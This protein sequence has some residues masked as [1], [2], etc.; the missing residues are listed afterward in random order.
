MLLAVVGAAGI[1][2]GSKIQQ[3]IT[4]SDLQ[5]LRFFQPDKLSVITN[6][7]AKDYVDTIN[8]NELIEKII[9]VVLDQLDPH[10]TYITAQEMSGVSEEMR[11]NFSGIG[12]QFI[13]QNDS[14]TVVDVV[15][16]GP[17]QKLGIMASEGCCIFDSVQ[18]QESRRF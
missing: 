5:N 7:I 11:G 10:S 1:F 9:P 18:G 6:M 12:V 4:K 16:G 15:S 8:K 13:M 14:V 2:I 17:S 3:N